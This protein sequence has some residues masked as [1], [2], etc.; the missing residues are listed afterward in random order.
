VAAL[1][2]GD[3]SPGAPLDGGLG[4]Q[5]QTAFSL[6][7][8]PLLPRLAIACLAL[9][10]PAALWLVLRNAS[11]RLLPGRGRPWLVLYALLPLLWSLMLA[12][13]LALGMAEGGR[14]LVVSAAPL[15]SSWRLVGDPSPL[16]PWLARLPAWCADPHVIGFCQ[17]LA[18]CVG[19]VGS[20]VLLRRL[21]LPA[22]LGWILQAAVT[23]VRAGAGRWLVAVG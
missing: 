18:V 9:A 23:L 4:L 12:H 19:M 1:A 8:G 10:L 3:A 22:R 14:V 13:H 16:L 11:A 20:V 21:L 15:L 2:A 5:A 17:T 6:G 7:V